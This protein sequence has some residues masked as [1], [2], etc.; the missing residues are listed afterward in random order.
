[1]IMTAHTSL[2]PDVLKRLKRAQGHVKSIL[3]M[4]EKG[5]GCPSKSRSHCKP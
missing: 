4:L 1:M 2:P 3:S 5:R